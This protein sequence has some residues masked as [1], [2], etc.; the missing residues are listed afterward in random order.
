MAENVFDA[1]TMKAFVRGR[2]QFLDRQRDQE[3]RERSEQEVVDAILALDAFYA[4]SA[5]GLP[6]PAA[7][8]LIEQQ[9]LFRKWGAK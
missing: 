6:A 5:S 9:R 7:S 3:L 2:A 8:G 4:S 1:A